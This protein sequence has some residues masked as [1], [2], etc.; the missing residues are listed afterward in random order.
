MVLPRPLDQGVRDLDRIK[1]SD[2][3]IGER[4]IIRVIDAVTGDALF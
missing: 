3:L 4:V 1:I 2:P